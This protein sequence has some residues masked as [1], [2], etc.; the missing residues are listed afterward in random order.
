VLVLG[1]VAV[2]VFAIWSLHGAQPL[3]R[4]RDAIADGDWVVARANAR[5]AARRTGG[6]SATPWRMLG[7]AEIA[8]RRPSDARSALRIA[9]ERDRGSW[10]SWY[11][12]ATVTTGNE[13]RAAIERA[14]DLNPRAPETQALTE[15]T[16]GNAS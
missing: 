14:R 11:D 6:F 12:L 10:E 1:G 2:G 16:P 7:E 13:R 5:E 15:T 9:I 8:L 4:A 3:A